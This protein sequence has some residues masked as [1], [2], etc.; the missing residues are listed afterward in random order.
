MSKLLALDLWQ[1]KGPFRPP[2]EL[3]DPFLRIDFI[4]EVDELLKEV[5][6]EENE[7]KIAERFDAESIANRL[8]QQEKK[9]TIQQVETLL[10]LAMSLEL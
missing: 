10:E 7:V 1:Q 6:D 3:E 9:R 2:P 5:R 4:R 8:K